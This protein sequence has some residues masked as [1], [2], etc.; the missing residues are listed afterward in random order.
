MQ[1]IDESRAK[2][3][4][5]GRDT[6]ADSYI[7]LPG[8]GLRTLQRR[9][10][11]VG[12]E[13][14]GRPTFHLKRLARMVRQHERRYMIGR[15]FAPPSFPGIVWPRTAHRAKHIASQNPC[16]NILHSS[17]RPLVIHAR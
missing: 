8:G 13:V 6:T 16:A 12:H 15:L 9:V 3:L 10:D 4:L 14:E 5:N 2:I 17:P 7:P 11:S 1:F